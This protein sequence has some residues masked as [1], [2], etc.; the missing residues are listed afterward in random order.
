MAY[1]TGHSVTDIYRNFVFKVLYS[2]RALESDTYK[3]NMAAN[4]I[5]VSEFG[6][7]GFPD[8]CKTLFQKYKS[9][10]SLNAVVRMNIFLLR[11]DCSRIS[12]LSWV[13]TPMI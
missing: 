7:T 9:N 6:T 3:K 2:S 8:P 4:R 12:N 11:L 10:D 13:T 1:I 5:I